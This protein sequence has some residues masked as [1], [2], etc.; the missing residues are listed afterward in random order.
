MKR[1]SR[2]N[3]HRPFHELAMAEILPKLLADRLGLP[4][5][6]IDLG[7]CDDRIWVHRWTEWLDTPIG[8]F[9]FHSR[10]CKDCG[11]VEGAMF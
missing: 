7:P 10:E 4:T 6:V 9:T 1:K 2:K 8:E 11:V 3:R 5:R